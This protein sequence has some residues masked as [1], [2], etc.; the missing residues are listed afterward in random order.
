MITHIFSI[1]FII[2]LRTYTSISS[3]HV[4]FWCMFL[5]N[6][7]CHTLLEYRCSLKKSDLMRS[8]FLIVEHTI[9]WI[10]VLLVIEAHKVF[11]G[12][13][14]F[15]CSLTLVKDLHLS[16]WVV[17]GRVVLR[18]GRQG[19]TCH[20]DIGMYLQSIEIVLSSIVNMLGKVYVIVW[21]VIQSHHFDLLL[22]YYNWEKRSKAIVIVYQEDKPTWRGGGTSQPCY[23]AM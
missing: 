2:N 14:V 15:L 1:V 3:W 4:S 22:N 13:F 21:R 17:Y 16:I 12:G 11:V 10:W 23:T 19:D 6:K 8:T 7:P 20:G 5:N 18:N 9:W